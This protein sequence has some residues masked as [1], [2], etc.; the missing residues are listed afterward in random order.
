MFQ[1]LELQHRYTSTYNTR[2]LQLQQKIKS[3]FKPP[4]ELQRVSISRVTTQIHSNLQHKESDHLQ[5]EMKST[6]KTRI[7]YT[8]CL[9]IQS[10]NTDT[11]QLTIQES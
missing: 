6:F 8:V 4:V 9:N 11:H 7:E 5:D 10:Y 2:K 3:T 1:F